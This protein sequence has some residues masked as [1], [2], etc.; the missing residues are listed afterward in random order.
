MITFILFAPF[1]FAV[2]A[3]LGRKAQKKMWNYDLPYEQRV[4]LLKK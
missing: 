3:W 4:K 2:G 1:A